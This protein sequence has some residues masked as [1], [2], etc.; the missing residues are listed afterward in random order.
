MP[1]PSDSATKFVNYVVDCSNDP[2][3]RAALR[4]GLARSV[5]QATRLHAYVAPWTKPERPHQEAVFYTIAALIAHKPD[6]AIPAQSP[7]NLGASLARCE[8]IAA[9]TREKSL[10]LVVR[11]PPAQ[12]CLMLTRIVLQLRDN[13]TPVDFA[14]LLDDAT[15]WHSH[16]QR[17]GRRWLQSYY[18]ATTP[19]PDAADLL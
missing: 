3:A 13:D 19:Q 17:I 2:G 9:A 7:G 4:S 5:D 11:Q 14:Q 12:L 10:H 1:S 15:Y 6:G 16:G 18:R 8:D